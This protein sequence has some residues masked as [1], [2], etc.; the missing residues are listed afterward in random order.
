MPV[1]G[2]NTR[3]K[4]DEATGPRGLIFNVQGY[5]VHDGPGIRTEF[6]L[7]GCSLSCEWCSNPEGIKL[8]AET[9]ID[10]KSVV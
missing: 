6:F 9:G 3:T 2:L 5:T 10:R 1:P 8:H 7:K 4:K